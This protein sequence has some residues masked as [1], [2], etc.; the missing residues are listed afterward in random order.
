ML[1]KKRFLIP[2]LMAALVMLFSACE[3][4]VGD[5]VMEEPEIRTKV[6]VLVAEGFHDGETFMPIGYLL[7]QGYD[8]TVIGSEPGTVKAY[9]SDFT[10]NIEKSVSDVSVDDFAALI[11]PGGRGPSVLREN[12]EVIE[13]VSAFWQTGKVTAAICH[14]PQVLITA[15]VMEGKTST[16]IGGIKDELEEAGVNFVDQSVV[17]DGNLI[18]SR[19]PD[20]LYDFSRTI[21]EE[22]TEQF[23]EI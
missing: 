18:T 7:N 11:L 17:V 23:T 10:I 16:G 14:G 4:R 22:I 5:V 9:N 8:I 12:D 15:G 20:D 6:A 13:F 19:M 3:S 1:R 2:A 21:H